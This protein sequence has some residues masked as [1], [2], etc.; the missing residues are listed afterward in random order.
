MVR[1]PLFV[2][3]PLP[4]TVDLMKLAASLEARGGN[5]KLAGALRNA[6]RA[7]SCVADL[8]QAQSACDALDALES[9]DVSFDPATLWQ[10]QT[11][12]LTSG[13][14]LYARATSTGGS[15]K[16][17]GSIQLDT[18]KL[19]HEQR[20]EHHMLVRL[21]NSA[22]GHVELGAEVAGD[23]WHRDFLFAKAVD[24]DDWQV[25]SASLAI[26]FQ[27]E[28]ARALKRQVPIAAELVAARCRQRLAVALQLLREAKPSDAAMRQH[29]VDP[30]DWFGSVEAALLALSGAPG[31]ETSA[32]LPLR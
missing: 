29:A 24:V 20:A 3:V 6:W 28:A 1:G 5:R 10:L 21:R 30:V 25:A 11:G 2:R 8:G 22:L 27:V 23:F 12:L 16:E 15:R 18:G 32:W 13:V 14:L 4:V 7:Q 31:E 19:T 26:G 17:R 9:A